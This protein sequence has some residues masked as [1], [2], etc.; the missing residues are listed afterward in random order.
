[1]T[2][3]L[4][5]VVLYLV[6]VVLFVA[7]EWSRSPKVGRPKPAERPPSRASERPAADIET[8]KAA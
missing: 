5:L 7:W 2:V 1:M 3:A 4:S 8:R 6:S